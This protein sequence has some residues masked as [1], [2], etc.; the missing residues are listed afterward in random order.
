PLI[1]ILLVSLLRDKW[2]NLMFYR[3]E[4]YIPSITGETLFKMIDEAG[5]YDYLFFEYDEQLDTFLDFLESEFHP[6]ITN[7]DQNKPKPIKLTNAMLKWLRSLPRYTQISREMNLEFV[8]LK[9]YIR[10]AEVDPKNTIE[11]L[12]YEYHYRTEEIRSFILDLTSYF[13]KKKEELEE[14]LYQLLGTNSFN[15][16]VSWAQKQN[17]INKKENKLVRC[18]SNVSNPKD[19]INELAFILVGVEIENW[20]DTT[21]EMFEIQLKNEY[22]KLI[23]NTNALGDYIQFSVNGLTK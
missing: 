2:D 18:L 7:E 5:E 3:N 9:K 16:T 15:E 12:Y 10:Q 19:W 6:Y 21:S 20:S 11:R 17:S 4:M 8:K 13:T 23:N 22:D 1:P 14:I